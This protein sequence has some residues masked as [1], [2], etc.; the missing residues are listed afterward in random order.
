MRDF[1]IV[2]GRYEQRKRGPER[3]D[4]YARTVTT[5][6]G[7]SGQ[8][9]ARFANPLPIELSAVL[10]DAIHNFRA[11][12]D[13][14]AWHLVSR[15][16]SGHT[17]HRTAF[18]IAESQHKWS[19]KF[20]SQLNG[21]G[22]AEE[23]FIRRLRAFNGGCTELYVLHRLDIV[24][25]H[26]FLAVPAIG[27]CDVFNTPVP[28]G[29]RSISRFPDLRRDALQAVADDETVLEF[30]IPPNVHL[31]GEY[32]QHL[33]IDIAVP[34]ELEDGSVYLLPADAIVRRI[35]YTLDKVFRIAQRRF[36]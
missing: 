5:S 36:P 14:L 2:I 29:A 10:G 27:F 11:S 7:R 6:D 9:I 13:H 12:L 8:V 31:A 35:S 21:I 26:R 24:D 33:V 34:V 32:H 19:E 25:K 15:S 17:D 1:K 20:K 3:R 22:S 28:D 30:A 23:R 18:P 4:L 16:P